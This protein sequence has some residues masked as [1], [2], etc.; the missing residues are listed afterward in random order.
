MPISGPNMA[1]AA[2]MFATVFMNFCVFGHPIAFWILRA[3]I[4][5]E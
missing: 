1:S 2:R 5:L 4:A 3:I